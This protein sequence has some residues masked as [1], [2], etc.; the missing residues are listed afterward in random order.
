MARSCKPRSYLPNS[1]GVGLL[2]GMV[3]SGAVAEPRPTLDDFYDRTR[4]RAEG[5]TR[6]LGYCDG[7][8]VLAFLAGAQAADPSTD[9]VQRAP[10]HGGRLGVDAGA[11]G[12]RYD[13]VR[14]KLWLDA[15]RVSRTGEAIT[16]LAWDSTVFKVW[17]EPGHDAGLHLSLST[18]LA[19]RSELLVSDVAEFQL[20]PYRLADAEVELTPTG[21]RIDKDTFWALPVGFAN[22]TRWSLEGDR[23][24]R[25]TNVSG[26][27]A[28]RGFSA[29]HFN[30]LRH[31]YQLDFL[32]LKRTDW[33]TPAGEA[34]SWTL[35]AGYQRLSPDVEWLEIWLL[36]GHEWAAGQNRRRG[37]V[38]QLGAEIT[39]RGDSGELRLSPALESHFVIDRTTNRFERVHDARLGF[40]HATRRL[41]WGLSYEGVRLG[42]TANL[43]AITPELGVRAFGL[44][45]GVRYR[46]AV[47]RD[48]RAQATPRDRFEFTADWMF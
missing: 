47:V 33:E 10:A 43:H 45:F 3:A 13:V 42:D 32:R 24:E 38:A 41:R 35:S 22:R 20:V 23:L 28:A 5:F 27:I 34:S 30:Q 21:P 37:F 25:R 11:F 8:V 19:Q 17:G 2:F 44:D 7:E 26:A 40:K 6:C 31:H 29:G 16:D 4:S 15:L 39:L 9:A 36:A 18:L 48:T 12:S 1:L 14:S 46:I